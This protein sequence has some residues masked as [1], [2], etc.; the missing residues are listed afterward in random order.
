MQHADGTD[1]V[2]TSHDFLE[3]AMNVLQTLSSPNAVWCATDTEQP[4]YR[5]L[6][7]T[8]KTQRAHV[9][10]G[11]DWERTILLVHSWG[12]SKTCIAGDATSQFSLLVH[13][14]SVFRS[15]CIT[16]TED[17]G[18]TPRGQGVECYT[19]RSDQH[20]FMAVDMGSNHNHGRETVCISLLTSPNPCKLLLA[21]VNKQ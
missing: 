5:L 4:Q 14:W 15:H 20:Y 8:D 3:D 11:Q 6:C 17:P 12:K 2:S 21:K 13:V 7:N 19:E 9:S 18:A 16:R 10:K 1:F